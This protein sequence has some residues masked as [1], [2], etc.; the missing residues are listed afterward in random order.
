[1]AKACKSMEELNSK[2]IENRDYKVLTKLVNANITILAIHSGGIEAGT[3]EVAERISITGNFNLF[4]FSGL[5]NDQLQCV[6]NEEIR[7]TS[8]KFQHPYL[9][10]LMDKSAYTVS[11]HGCDEEN[12]FLFVGGLDTE[13]INIIKKNLRSRGFNVPDKIRKGLEG[14]NS[15]NVCNRNLRNKGVQLEIPEG[16]RKEMFGTGWKKLEDR[17]N[18]KTDRFFSF[19]QCIV[20]SIKE[21]NM[22]FKDER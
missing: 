14:I 19:C 22:G 21:F 4:S 8:S 17:K 3:S 9:Q 20:E 7:V 1:M 18:K 5:I 12:P 15:K 11:V 2:Y 6:E 10:L 13:L 16:L